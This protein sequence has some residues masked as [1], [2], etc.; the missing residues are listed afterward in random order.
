MPF[1]AFFAI[2]GLFALG[3]VMSVE[4]TICTCI[5]CPNAIEYL[6]RVEVFITRCGGMTSK[7]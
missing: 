3:D 6:R 5:V 7:A 1:I 4:K 2:V